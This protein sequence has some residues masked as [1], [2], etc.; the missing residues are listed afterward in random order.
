MSR[1]L[2]G[3]ALC[4]PFAD[5]CSSLQLFVA[6][7]TQ[8]SAGLCGFC[9]PL[10]TWTLLLSVNVLG[11]Q[12][13]W[14]VWRRLP[15]TNLTYQYGQVA[16]AASARIILHHLASTPSLS[17]CI[18]A[19]CLPRYQPPARHSTCQ[20]QP[21]NQLAKAATFPAIF[22]LCPPTRL[23]PAS[24]LAI[25]PTRDRVSITNS[26]YIVLPNLSPIHTTRTARPVLTGHAENNSS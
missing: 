10:R 3:T 20:C 18:H 7:C 24:Y 5:L 16:A 26:R 11:G 9:S 13:K 14:A 6:L 19:R 25:Q 2:L 1:R 8:Y 12:M 15:A 23:H 21:A 22:L 4:Q 17:S